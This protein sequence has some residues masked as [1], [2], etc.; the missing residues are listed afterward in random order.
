[1]RHTIFD[2]TAASLRG[3]APVMFRNELLVRSFAGWFG[4]AHDLNSDFIPM[5][6][7]PSVFGTQSSTL[8]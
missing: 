2:T 1:M 3:I 7:S 8:Q 4:L 6:C 5:P